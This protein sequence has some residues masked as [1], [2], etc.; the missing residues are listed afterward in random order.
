MVTLSSNRVG[1]GTAGRTIADLDTDFEIVPFGTILLTAAATAGWAGE[2]VGPDTEET[3]LPIFEA[4]DGWVGPSDLALSMGFSP[5]E[6]PNR[7]EHARAIELVGSK[8]LGLL[9]DV[10]KGNDIEIFQ[11]LHRL[12]SSSQ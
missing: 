8:L 3:G 4:T 12:A 11:A 10:G 5:K 9:R 1:W 7:G 2:I 6:A